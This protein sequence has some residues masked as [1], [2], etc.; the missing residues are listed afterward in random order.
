MNS[1]ITWGTLEDAIKTIMIPDDPAN[2]H[3]IGIYMY[4]FYAFI[5]TCCFNQQVNPAEAT[6]NDTIAMVERTS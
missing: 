3:T 4:I 5:C 1:S 2:D 6:N